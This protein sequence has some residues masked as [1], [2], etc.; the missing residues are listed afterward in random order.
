MTFFFSRSSV[1]E[2]PEISGARYSVKTAFE[3][4]AWSVWQMSSMAST[5]SR[6]AQSSTARTM[7]CGGRLPPG[8]A[9]SL[10]AIVGITVAGPSGATSRFCP[11]IFSRAAAAQ[12]RRR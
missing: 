3:P 10:S 4:W 11:S 6:F 1:C 8:V 5:P 9:R 2:S 12:R 7:N